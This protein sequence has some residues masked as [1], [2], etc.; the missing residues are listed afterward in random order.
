MKRFETFLIIKTSQNMKKRWFAMPA[1][2]L[3][4]RNFVAGYYV[5]SKMN[6]NQ[7]QE[8]LPKIDAKQTAA[9]NID[10]TNI[11]GRRNRATQKRSHNIL[12]PKTGEHIKESVQFGGVRL[13]ERVPRRLKDEFGA[14]H[15]R[16]HGEPN[17]AP[18]HTQL[19]LVKMREVGAC[20][21][22]LYQRSTGS[23]REIIRL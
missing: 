10:N 1:T 15:I 13:H 7:C 3:F 23:L 2:P 8:K 4:G 18:G 6:I 17:G 14:R 16:G 19:R 9:N 20:S 12:N 21:R 11:L 5:R 22:S